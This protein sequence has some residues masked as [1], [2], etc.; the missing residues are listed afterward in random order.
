MTDKKIS[1]LTAASTPLAGTEVLPIVQ[2]STTVKV[3]TDDLTVKNIRSN[4]TNGLLQ[5]VGPAASSTRIMTVPDAN[6]TAARIDA[7]N[8]FTGNQ[9]L[10]TGNLVVGTAGKGVDFSAN[11]NAAGM[12]SELLTWYEEGTWTPALQRNSGTFVCTYTSRVGIYTR[13][14]RLVT[15]YAKIVIDTI[16]AAGNAANI[17]QGIPFNPTTTTGVGVV[18]LDS[19]FTSNVK[20]IQ[21]QNFNFEWID[22]NGV[23]V[24]EDYVA[25]GTVELTIT[26]TV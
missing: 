26:Y 16:S 6:F 19:A 11:T 22:A 20:A 3:A 8:S 14:G 10:S 12:T 7:A 18:S 17:L 23:S 4:A 25:G 15:L 1:Q 24:N 2:S 5:I 9:T 21:A 13:V